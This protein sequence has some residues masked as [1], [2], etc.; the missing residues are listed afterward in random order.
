MDTHKWCEFELPG[1]VVNSFIEQFSDLG[2]A[3]A[4]AATAD[5]LSIILVALGGLLTGAAVLI[6]GYLSLRSVISGLG[7][8]AQN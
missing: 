3:F 7:R 1:M 5:P 8:A 4:E 2:E 6:F